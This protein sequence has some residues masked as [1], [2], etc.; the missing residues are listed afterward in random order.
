MVCRPALS[1]LSHTSQGKAVVFETRSRRDHGREGGLGEDRITGG[2]EVWEP[3]D[4]DSSRITFLDTEIPSNGDGNR[5]VEVSLKIKSWRGEVWWSGS[6]DVA[7]GRHS[8]L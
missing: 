7:Q 8:L 6:E 5:R 1:P 2:E 3:R 4:Q